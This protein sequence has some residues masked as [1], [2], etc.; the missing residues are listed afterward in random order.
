MTL[1]L[2]GMILFIA[3]TF[4]IIML[5]CIRKIPPGNA[6]VRVGVGGYVVSDTWVLGIPFLTTYN[7]MDI[8]V[9]KLEIARKG[10]N[11]LICQDNIRADIVVAFYIRVNYPKVDYGGIAPSSPE[12]QAMMEAAMRSKNRFDDVRK[13]AQT[14]GCDRAAEVDKL[15]ELF[16]AK[17]SEA[18]KTA[19]KMMDFQTLNT[20]QMRF[21]DEIKA[22]I[23]QDLEGYTLT[24]VAIDYLE[25]TPLE[26]LDQ[27]NVLDAEGIKKIT[28]IASADAEVAN[29]RIQQKEMLTKQQD[30]RAQMHIRELERTYEEFLAQTQRQLADELAKAFPNMETVEEIRAH[31]WEDHFV[32]DRF[33]KLEEE[34]ERLKLQGPNRPNKIEEEI[35][36]LKPQGPPDS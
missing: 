20:E 23:G 9:Q 1:M 16:E 32:W 3:L 7:K 8:T 30:I 22:I 28:M 11:G 34:I 14:V 18:L 10:G 26:Y 4:G 36:P 27:D 31:I 33:K 29:E 5:F 12:G 24:D 15:H 13:V 21:R 35:E 6:G 2:V 25:Q 17:F 19:G